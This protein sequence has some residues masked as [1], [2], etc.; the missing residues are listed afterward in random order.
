MP[1]HGNVKTVFGELYVWTC[2]CGATQ[3]M[4]LEANKLYRQNSQTFYCVHGHARHY[5]QGPTE[6]DKLREQLDDERRE[7][8]RAEQQIEYEA[9]IRRQETERAD[10]ERARAN[11][12]E[13]HA[14]RITKR[15]KA[16]VC[17][18]CNRTFQ[19]LAKHMATKHPQFTPIEL[20]QGA[21]VQ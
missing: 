5:P 20:E 7:R 14:T 9:Q 8:Q 3:A 16:G 6:E 1:T 13:G 17:P 12:Y 2:S 18:C 21:T 10:R 15:A 19:Q 11:G 4:S